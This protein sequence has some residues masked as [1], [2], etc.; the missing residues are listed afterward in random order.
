MLGTS[1]DLSDVG[2]NE[3][4]YTTEVYYGWDI[5]PIRLEYFIISFDSKE[6]VTSACRKKL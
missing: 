4:Y 3:L 6:R 2:S 1:D 5:D